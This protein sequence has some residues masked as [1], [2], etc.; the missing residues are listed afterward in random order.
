M[1]M[2]AKCLHNKFKA[3]YI[4]NSRASIVTTS[5]ACSVLWEGSNVSLPTKTS[6][7]KYI[8]LFMNIEQVLSYISPDNVWSSNAQSFQVDFEVCLCLY[9]ASVPVSDTSVYI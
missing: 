3:V 4:L 2:Y 1:E 7:L 6:L 5:H 9:L 8:L